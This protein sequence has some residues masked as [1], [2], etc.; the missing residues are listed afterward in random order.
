MTIISLL[1]LLLYKPFD[2]SLLQ[3][4]EVFNE[5]TSLALLYTTLCWLKFY[6]PSDEDQEVWFWIEDEPLRENIGNFFN[7]V[8]GLN[9]SVHLYF[10]FRSLYRDCKK[11]AQIKKLKKQREQ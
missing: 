7:A 6:D 10:L 5:F 2:T 9:V 4:L 11:M 3:N 1:Y 8:M